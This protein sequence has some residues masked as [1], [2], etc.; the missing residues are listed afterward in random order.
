MVVEDKDS[1]GTVV[2]VVDSY[3]QVKGNQKVNYYTTFMHFASVTI[4]IVNL[5]IAALIKLLECYYLLSSIE[6]LNSL[7]STNQ[8]KVF[9]SPIIKNDNHY[10]LNYVLLIQCVDFTDK[11]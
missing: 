10:S 8:S 1:M 6:Q 4:T 11:Y 7:V 3:M 9:L 2:K 5:V